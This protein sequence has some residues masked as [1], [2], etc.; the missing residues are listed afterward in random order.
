[1]RFVR[2][3]VSV[4]CMLGVLS[5]ATPSVAVAAPTASEVVKEF[6]GVLADTMK[7]GPELGFEGRYKKLDPAITKAFNLPLMARYSVGPTWAATSPEDQQKLVDAFSKFSISTY[8]SRFKKF[9]GEAFIVV[10]EK[11]MT[12]GSGFMVQTQLKP[13]DSEAVTLNYLVRPDDKGAL[14]IADVYLDASISELATRRAEFSSV[15]KREGFPSLL[16]S[17]VQ[18]S[19]KMQEAQTK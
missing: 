16:A 12:N 15:I 18:K 5:C 14:R 1:M 13:K 10:S 17:L 19:V 11:T 6:Y 7:Q 3:F 8:A 2:Q 9:D 4:F